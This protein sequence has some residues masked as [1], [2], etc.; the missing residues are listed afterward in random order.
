MILLAALCALAAFA[1]L[2]MAVDAHHRR[3]A[4]RRLTAAAKGLLR[5]A[6]WLALAVSF[7]AVIAARGWVFGPVIWTGLVMFGAGM[8]FLVLN[9]A[10]APFRDKAG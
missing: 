2:G 7:I 1:A 3:W 4:G 6:A 5:G 8:V 9:L 10:P